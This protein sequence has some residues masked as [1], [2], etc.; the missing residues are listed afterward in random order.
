M[1]VR[2]MFLV[3]KKS[4]VDLNGKKRRQKPKLP[5]THHRVLHFRLLQSEFV[6]LAQST[7]LLVSV[8]CAVLVLDT[9][10][11]AHLMWVDI[12]F[13][14]SAGSSFFGFR[15]LHEAF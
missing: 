12:M 15:N 6:T 4:V 14:K 10:F 2:G 1:M 11:F 9:L 8:S 5:H 7:K 3:I 13:W